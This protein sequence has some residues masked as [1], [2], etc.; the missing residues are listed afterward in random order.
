MQGPSL[1]ARRPSCGRGAA[2]KGAFGGARS[3]RTLDSARLAPAED[4]G[5]AIKDGCDRGGRRH[6]YS[7]AFA[8]AL[9]FAFI[10]ISQT[11]S[12]RAS[13]QPVATT[14]AMAASM[15]STIATQPGQ[16]AAFQATPPSVAPTLPPI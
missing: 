7:F 3:A 6:S 2:V 12:Q 9:V 10:S 11:D 16:P 15:A 1:I 5:V 14:A 8:F 13:R 4:A